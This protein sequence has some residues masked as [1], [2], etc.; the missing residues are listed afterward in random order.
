MNTDNLAAKL[1]GK[2]IVFDGPDGGG[3]STQ[4]AMLR[5]HLTKLGA[6]VASARDPGGTE[7][8]NRVRHVLL[9]FDLQTMDVRC[10]TFLF[11]ASRAQL[12][13]EIVEPALAEGGVVLCDR[14]ISATYAY[15]GA[16]GYEVSQLLDLGNMAVG[17]CWPHVTIV[18]DLPVECAMGRLQSKLDA[19]ESR[20]RE[21]HER[22]RKIFLE[23]P[24]MYPGPVH[25]VDGSGTPDEVHRRV[26][27]MLGRVVL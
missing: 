19:M 23:L 7:I 16:A 12:V 13:S 6:N 26:V 15:Q 9:D 22:V 8:G 14:F 27:E 24:S 20:P 18:I 11:M 3:K 5:D 21:F 17:N 4:V 2:F 1:S 25:I 10:E